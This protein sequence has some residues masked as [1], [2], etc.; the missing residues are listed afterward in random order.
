MKHILISLKQD[1]YHFVELIW[2]DE[3]SFQEWDPQIQHFSASDSTS[4]CSLLGHVYL[5][6]CQYWFSVIYAIGCYV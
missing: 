3:F 2:I 1:S 4:N 5:L 6:G